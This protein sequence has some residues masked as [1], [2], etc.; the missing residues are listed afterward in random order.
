M[1]DPRHLRS[2]AANKFTQRCLGLYQP[3]LC[4]PEGPCSQPPPTAPAG[5]AV[6]SS[7]WSALSRSLRQTDRHDR[8]RPAQAYPFLVIET[9]YLSECP[10]ESSTYLR[11]R[12][13]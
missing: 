3:T 8:V 13:S 12:A 2:S 1:S 4:S 11:L 6:L 5:G 7:V 9:R 10:W